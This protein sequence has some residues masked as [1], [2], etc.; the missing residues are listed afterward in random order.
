MKKYYLLIIM[1]VMS[2]L[3]IKDNDYI[4]KDKY[5]EESMYVF[6][7]IDGN[8][9]NNPDTSDIHDIVFLLFG[10]N[11]VLVVML[12]FDRKKFIKYVDV[13]IQSFII[14]IM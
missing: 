4:K 8:E 6:Y 9:V 11:V 14:D 2:L 3:L 12:C 1:F 13:K 10:Y 5:Y 7:E